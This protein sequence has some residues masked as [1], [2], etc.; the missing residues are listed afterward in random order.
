MSKFAKQQIKSAD[1]ACN[2]QVGLTYPSTEDLK[3]IVQ[4]NMLKDCPVTHQDVDVAIKIWGPCVALLKGKTVRCKPPV[5]QQDIIEVP[6]EI[7][8][9]C[10]KVALVINSFLINNIPFF[11]TFSLRICYKPYAHKICLRIVSY[12]MRNFSN[13]IICA[14]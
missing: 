14:H 3:R 5:V 4:A 12:H 13:K 7:W 1:D 10:K 9:L 6:R 8:Q 11:V 2:I